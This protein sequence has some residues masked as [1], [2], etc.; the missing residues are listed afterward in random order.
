[1]AFPH[2]ASLLS[3]AVLLACVSCAGSGGQGSRLDR[4]LTGRGTLN[5]PS[6]R[7]TLSEPET[8]AALAAAK[9]LIVAGDPAGALE[10]L[11]AACDRGPTGP[12][13]P[14]VRELRGNLRRQSELDDLGL[15]AWIAV[16]E[17]DFEAGET[18]RGLLVLENGGDQL[19]RISAGV[20]AFPFGWLGRSES[21]RLV[22]EGRY[23]EH[24]PY[25]SEVGES[26]QQ[27]EEL[28]GDIVLK[29]GQR[30]E[31]LLDVP[32]A[33]SP[34]FLVRE[35]V[36]KARLLATSI[37]L[38]KVWHPAHEIE[39]A[40]AAFNA[41]LRGYRDIIPDPLARLQQALSI[42]DRRTDPHVLVTS[43][44]MPP[45]DIRAAAEMLIATLSRSESLRRRF[46]IMVALRQITG[47]RFSLE[48]KRWLNWWRQIND[49][50]VGRTPAPDG[51][52]D[53]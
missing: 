18:A 53:R 22:I 31:R 37:E 43:T 38:G 24:D 20:D 7:E 45:Q 35:Y 16:R 15:S 13:A 4:A 2:G 17:F 50:L 49:P 52:A 48:E 21:S 23:T 28:E 46:A 12:D 8:T 42:E 27:I 41:Y 36:M 9:A 25:G 40:P 44:L 3:A 51:E 11:E 14:E 6:R 19:V 30:W 39:F 26:W 47:R 10:K 32:I 34:P 5:A 29:P 1:M 33:E